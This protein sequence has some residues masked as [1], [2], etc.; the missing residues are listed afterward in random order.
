[1]R[2]SRREYDTNDAEFDRDLSDRL[3]SLRM[4][5]IVQP[6]SVLLSIGNRS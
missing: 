3:N 2:G 1:M 6:S 4:R 5:P